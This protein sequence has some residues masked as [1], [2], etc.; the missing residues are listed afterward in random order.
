MVLTTVKTE[1]TVSNCTFHQLCQKLE[2]I[3]QYSSL[4]I[5]VSITLRFVNIQGETYLIYVLPWIG[6]AYDMRVKVRLLGFR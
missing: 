1:R 4:V 3:N 6:E 2:K 5:S